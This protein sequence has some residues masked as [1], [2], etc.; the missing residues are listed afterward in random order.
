VRREEIVA[1]YVHIYFVSL[2]KSK[3]TVVISATSLSININDSKVR[4][5]RE[6]KRKM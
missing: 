3:K 4:L 6:I 2:F 1:K 5:I